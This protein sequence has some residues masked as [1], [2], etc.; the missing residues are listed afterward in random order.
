LT[1]IL[2]TQLVEN[3]L[4]AGKL[5]GKNLNASRIHDIHS[6]FK[7]V[8]CNVTPSLLIDAGTIPKTGTSKNILF[9]LNSVTY[10]DDLSMTNGKKEPIY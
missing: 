6:S 7:E 4:L 10:R 1:I 8:P 5:E 2:P 3:F 9:L